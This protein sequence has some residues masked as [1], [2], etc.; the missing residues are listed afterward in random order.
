[1]LEFVGRPNTLR[2]PSIPPVP[3]VLLVIKAIDNDGRLEPVRGFLTTPW[4]S[5]V[6]DHTDRPAF[7][8]TLA[9]ADA[10]IS[11][12]WSAG[13]PAAPRLKL[14][15]LPGAGLDD[16]DFAAVPADASVCNAYEHEIGIAEF[17]LAAMLEWQIRIQRMDTEFRQGRWW[18]GFLHG[19]RHQELFG[20]TLGIVGYGRIGREVAKRACAFGMRVIAVNRT[21]RHGDGW[22]ECVSGMDGL[23]ELLAE[24]H[25]V[26]AALPLDRHSHGVFDRR[27][28]ETMR[29]D[30]VIINVGRGL[31]IDEQA[32]FEA[33]RD[34]LIGGAVIDTWYSYPA[35]GSDAGTIHRASRFA[36]HELD[37]VVMTPH[38]SAWTD[39]L[40]ERRCRI[41]A[42]NLDRL[43]RGEP[44]LNLVRGPSRTSVAA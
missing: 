5:V 40:I 19:P 14:L 10:A 11:M 39:A 24:S 13:F 7:A 16:I 18:G 21:P 2:A 31:T 23:R 32:L 20:R 38:A 15:Q 26:L 22:C 37:N 17:V 1:M 28:F 8:R 41:I 33:C 4:E 35:Q 9:D 29:R 27:A 30:A 43:T 3:I 34:R 36:F 25:F 42:G 44:L 12:N 6:S